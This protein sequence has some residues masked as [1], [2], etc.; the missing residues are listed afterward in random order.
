MPPAGRA[1]ALRPGT[2][3]PAQP[4][5]CPL[6]NPRFTG[7]ALLAGLRGHPAL[8]AQPTPPKRYR[9]GG[10]LPPNKVVASLRNASVAWEGETLSPGFPLPNPPPSSRGWGPQCR[11]RLGPGPRRAPARP[12]RGATHRSASLGVAG[13]GGPVGPPG[14]IRSRYLMSS[15]SH[16]CFRETSLAVFPQKI[17]VFPEIPLAPP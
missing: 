11:C 7:T 9:G 5:A 16:V 12:H 17:A 2:A 6:R 1:A 8:G 15:P 4:A 3:E 13:P 14:H 10:G